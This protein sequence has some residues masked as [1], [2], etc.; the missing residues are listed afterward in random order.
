MAWQ[1]MQFRLVGDAPM[2]QHNGQTADPLNRFSKQLKALSGKKKKTDSDLEEMAKIEFM[3]GLYLSKE[4]PIIPATMID[5]C[6]IEAA[7]KAREGALLSL[8]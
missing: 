5:A 6:V 3:A 2:I 1:K 7:K 4:G 8:T